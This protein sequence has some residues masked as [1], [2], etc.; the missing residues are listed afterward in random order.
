MNISYL[1]LINIK[2]KFPKIVKNW[3]KVCKVDTNYFVSTIELENSLQKLSG[4]CYHLFGKYWGKVCQV[5]SH[6]FVSRVDLEKSL[7][8]LFREILSFILSDWE[9][10]C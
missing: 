4:K 10:V 8:T 6:Y 2:E 7:R 3:G 1:S 5:E 9:N